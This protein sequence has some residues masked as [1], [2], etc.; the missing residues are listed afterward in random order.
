M[1]L[2]P[3]PG[4]K[5]M[6]AERR[7]A[8]LDFKLD[9]ARLRWDLPYAHVVAAAVANYEA[10]E[11]T[12]DQPTEIETAASDYIE[13]INTVGNAAFGDEAGGWGHGVS[14]EAGGWGH[15]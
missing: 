6:S 2:E 13:K 3:W 5:D 12:G 4:Y 7:K 15:G 11:R 8:L 14:D 1:A 10:L 9:E